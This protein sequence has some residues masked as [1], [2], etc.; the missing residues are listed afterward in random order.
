MDKFDYRRNCAF[1]TYAYPWIKD[2]IRSALSR[3]L[4]ITLPRHIYKLLIKV[5]TVQWKLCYEL[6]RLPDEEELRTEMN[7]SIEKFE[8]VKRAMALA[9][10]STDS[11]PAANTKTF[12]QIHE[13]TW[14]KIYSESNEGYELEHVQSSFQNNEPLNTIQKKDVRNT[15]FSILNSLP[16]DE[17]AAIYI[18]LGLH[19]FTTSSIATSNSTSSSAFD[20]TALELFQSSISKLKNESEM[21]RNLLYHKAIKKLRRRLLS[22]DKEYSELKEYL[23]NNFLSFST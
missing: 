6:G 1:S 10:H 20:T 19:E 11:T 23:N 15:L 14:E 7:L 17:A 9:S 8:I 21:V 22:T 2:Y 16:S 12:F 18:K 4:P 5:K 13:S 3:S